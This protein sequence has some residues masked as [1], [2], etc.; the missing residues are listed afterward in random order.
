MD[1]RE[2]GNDLNG[3]LAEDGLMNVKRLFPILLVVLG[4]ELF[5]GAI[6]FFVPVW[7][8][9]IGLQP[10]NRS[11][12]FEIPDKN[13]SLVE[14]FKQLEYDAFAEGLIT[15]RLKPYTIMP[16]TDSMK[17][18]L[19]I[20]IFGFDVPFGRPDDDTWIR[21]AKRAGKSVVTCLMILSVLNSLFADVLR[22]L[23]SSAGD[24]GWVALLLPLLFTS[25]NYPAALAVWAKLGIQSPAA[26]LNLVPRYQ[27]VPGLAAIGFPLGCGA[28]WL[29][30][31]AQ[32]YATLLLPYVLLQI[33]GVFYVYIG[34]FLM[35]LL[36]LLSVGNLDLH[37]F[38]ELAFMV[39]VIFEAMLVVMLFTWVYSK[40]IK[41]P[42]GSG[43]FTFTSMTQMVKDIFYSLVLPGPL[44][45]SEQDKE[46]MIS[47]GQ[48]RYAQDFDI[49][50]STVSA[51]P[52]ASSLLP[53]RNAEEQEHAKKHIKVQIVFRTLAFLVPIAFHQIAA[54]MLGRFFVLSCPVTG[55]S[56]EARGSQQ[57]RM[58]LADSL[59]ERHLATYIHYFVNSSARIAAECIEDLEV[60]MHGANALHHVGNPLADFIWNFF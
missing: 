42:S 49:H 50:Y 37:L 4:V 16:W 29:P 47:V 41:V 5:S 48:E 3:A 24:S 59:N 51:D 39:A 40:M 18:V 12:F 25:A 54:T 33:V 52:E 44:K 23:R 31:L 27:T 21:K 35:F 7:S 43:I 22:V 10:V 20:F 1:N 36:G 58:L 32:L 46:M 19:T 53:Q 8:P 60:C 45:L 56:F 30:G 26:L 2:A 15:S 57:I 17:V 28:T 14:P 6:M 34:L 11:S 13:E 9:L 55:S 38:L